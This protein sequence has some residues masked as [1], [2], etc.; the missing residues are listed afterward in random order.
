MPCMLPQWALYTSPCPCPGTQSLLQPSEP[1]TIPL[2]PLVPPL[3]YDGNTGHPLCLCAIPIFYTLPKG[4]C[5]EISNTWPLS[6]PCPISDRSQ[7][8]P[9]TSCLLSRS[10]GQPFPPV[11]TSWSIQSIKQYQLSYLP[12]SNSIF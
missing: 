6:G 10:A 11:T 1:T 8:F 12:P 2:D 9:G 7:S 4:K 5:S 3:I